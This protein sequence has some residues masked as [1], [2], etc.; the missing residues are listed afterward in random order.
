M[1]ISITSFAK[2]KV[3]LQT[4][5]SLLITILV[6]VL[7]SAASCASSF[8]SASVPKTEASPP[9][10][11]DVDSLCERI[12]D[13]KILPHKDEPV[14]DPAYNAL[15]DAG[16]KAIPCLITKIT[17]TTAMQ[18]PRQAP[19]VTGVRVGDVAY[20]LFVDLGKLDFV[21]LLPPDAQKGYARDGVYGYFEHINERNNRQEL[22]EAAY[23]W[24]EHKY[25]RNLRKE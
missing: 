22:Q 11:I 5:L 6:V 24:Y 16:E 10:P 12:V 4:N 3:F 8:H 14:D 18:D 7:S 9:H 17:D 15:L 2:Y 1:S 19:K 21:E 13:I 23:K 25:G 20:F